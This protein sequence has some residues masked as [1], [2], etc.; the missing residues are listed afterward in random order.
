MKT[1]TLSKVGALAIALGL[2]STSFAHEICTTHRTHYTAGY[3]YTPASDTV[4]V[5]PAPVVRYAPVTLVAPA[6]PPFR[7][8]HPFRPGVVVID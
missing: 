4:I 3:D 5:R 7:S 6:V 2:A 1:T 8:F